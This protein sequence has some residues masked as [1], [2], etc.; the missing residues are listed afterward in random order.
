MWHATEE[1]VAGEVP[2]LPLSLLRSLLRSQEQGQTAAQVRPDSPFA[3]QAVATTATVKPLSSSKAAHLWRSELAKAGPLPSL[4][5]RVEEAV[6][7]AGL[8]R[9]QV[10]VSSDPL[11]DP[12]NPETSE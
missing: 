4:P 6:F 8:R 12:V 10:E 1:G 11:N 2:G 9:L 5:G 3:H 7:L